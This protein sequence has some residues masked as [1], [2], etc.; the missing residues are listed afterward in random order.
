MSKHIIVVIQVIKIFLYSSSVYSCQL[1]LISSS[2]VRS[3]LF[4]SYIVS[5]IAGNVPLISLIFLK[6]SLVFPNLL[7]FYFILFTSTF[8]LKRFSYL[9]LLFSGILHS[10]GYIFQLAFL[11]STDDWVVSLGLNKRCD[12]QAATFKVFNKTSSGK[13]WMVGIFPLYWAWGGEL[14]WVLLSPLGTVS[15]L[16]VVLYTMWTEAF[17]PSGLDILSLGWKS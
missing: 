10:D 7:F 5:I 9:S 4:L 12:L 2:S 13:G 15:L 11:F 3:K 14:Q 8:H 17:C 6:R 16:A 1:F